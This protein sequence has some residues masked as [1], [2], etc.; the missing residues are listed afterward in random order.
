MREIDFRKFS[1]LRLLI[2]LSDKFVQDF[3]LKITIK[4]FIKSDLN[5]SWKTFIEGLICSKKCG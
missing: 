1:C 4:I 5:K 2:M 3:K